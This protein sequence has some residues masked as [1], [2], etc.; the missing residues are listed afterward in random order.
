M[1]ASRVQRWING[2]FVMPAC[3]DKELCSF[4]MISHTTSGILV[5]RSRVYRVSPLSLPRFRV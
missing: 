4:L 5:L 2:F 1:L 3:L